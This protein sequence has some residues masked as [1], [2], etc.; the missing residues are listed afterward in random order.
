MEDVDVEDVLVDE[1][2]LEEG[3][4]NEVLGDKVE[5]EVLVVLLLHVNDEVLE[6]EDVQL[7]VKGNGVYVNVGASNGRRSA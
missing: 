3:E 6:V 4:I 1:V 7:E 5:V 2:E